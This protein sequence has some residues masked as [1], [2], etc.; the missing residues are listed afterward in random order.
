MN[1]FLKSLL[2]TAVYL[3]DQS[4][5]V[6][7]DLKDRF[8]DGVDQVNDRVSDFR[9]RAQGFYGHRD[10]T[11]RNVL[12]FTAGVGVG[13][14]LG[15]LLAPASGEET[16]STIGNKVQEMGSQVRSRFN[17]VKRG[18]TGTEGV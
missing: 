16:R 18:A 8:A 7:E 13:V 10:N 9:D 12:T 4:D 2:K 3:L 14:G 11:L 5:R 15:I 6:A 17:D 1:K